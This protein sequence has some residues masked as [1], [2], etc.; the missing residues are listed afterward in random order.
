MHQFIDDIEKYFEVS[1]WVIEI[2]WCIGNIATQIE[3]SYQKPLSY[4]TKGLRSVYGQLTQTVDGTVTAYSNASVVV[5]LQAVDS[6]Y[7]EICS[8]NSAFLDFM[9]STYGAYQ[10]KTL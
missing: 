2:E 10:P 6:S 9:T 3:R 7:W 4:S 8:A 5:R 1:E